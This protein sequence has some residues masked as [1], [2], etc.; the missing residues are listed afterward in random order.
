MIHFEMSSAGCTHVMLEERGVP[1]EYH[2]VDL[3]TSA[4]TG[5][6]AGSRVATGMETSKVR[7]AWQK[8]AAAG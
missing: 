3:P 8:A 4:M 1:Y 2:Q 6:R 7:P 5:G